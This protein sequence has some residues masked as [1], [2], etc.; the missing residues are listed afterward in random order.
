MKCQ[1]AF[2][3]ESV[4][5]FVDVAEVNVERAKAVDFLARNDRGDL[6]LG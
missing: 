1:S 4:E 3:A 5:G 6:W 2:E